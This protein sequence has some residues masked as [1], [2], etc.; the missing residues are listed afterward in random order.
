MDQVSE[1]MA[2]NVVQSNMYVPVAC[3]SNTKIKKQCYVWCAL[4]TNEKIPWCGDFD[5]QFVFNDSLKHI[6]YG[7]IK[8]SGDG[9]MC[10]MKLHNKGTEDV[11][12]KKDEDVGIIFLSQKEKNCLLGSSRRKVK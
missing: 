9:H 6:T 5:L 2:T 1:D 11:H 7:D 4:K 10:L 12:L 8:M 3:V